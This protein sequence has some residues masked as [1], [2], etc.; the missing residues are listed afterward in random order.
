VGN[1]ADNLAA[2]TLPSG[3][4]S[5]ASSPVPSGVDTLASWEPNWS[6]WLAADDSADEVVAAAAAS[7]KPKL[8]FKLGA[9]IRAAG[10]KARGCGARL[11]KLCC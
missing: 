3:G 5:P 9:A 1:T 8:R 6:E 11:K 7:P 10:D 2:S 4:D